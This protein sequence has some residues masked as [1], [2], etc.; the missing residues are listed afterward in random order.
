[1]AKRGD[2]TEY[3][4][5]N[6]DAAEIAGRE[7]RQLVYGKDSPYARETEYATVAAVTLGDLQAWHEKTVVP[8]N[9][10]VAVEGDF[11]SA[12]ME[13]KLRRRLSR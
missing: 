9:M 7:V 5:R 6:D 1:M 12:T 11:D 2:D 13:A 3:P 4:R 8:N 10:I